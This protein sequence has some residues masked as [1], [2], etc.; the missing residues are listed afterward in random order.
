MYKAVIFDFFGV[1][2]SDPFH[3]WLNRHELDQSGELEESSQ[4][5]DRGEINDDEFYRRLADLSGQTQQNVKK[6]FGD[7]DLIDKDLVK[8]IK[9][10]GPHYKIGLLSNSS[11]RYLRPILEQHGL[12]EL[13]DE[14]TVSAEVG[15]IKPDLAIF[16]HVLGELGVE[17]GEALFIDDNPRNVAAA[18]SVGMGALVFTGERALRKELA[19]AGIKVS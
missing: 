4:L 13:F 10:L 14:I 18:K 11:G 2:H 15:L 8:L 16:H 6:V 12:L 9:E 1:I 7:T 19:A 5:L 3:R 17:A